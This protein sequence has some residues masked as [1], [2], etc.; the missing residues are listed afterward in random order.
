MA[1]GTAASLG[2]LPSEKMRMA[3]NDLLGLLHLKGFI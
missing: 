3:L 2:G 1:N